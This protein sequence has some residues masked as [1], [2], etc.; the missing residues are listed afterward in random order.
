MVF[1][2]SAYA[3]ELVADVTQL[4]VVMGFTGISTDVEAWS[5]NNR[6]PKAHVGK[7]EPGRTRAMQEKKTGIAL[8]DAMRVRAK[9]LTDGTQVFLNCFLES[10][11]RSA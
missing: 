4:L 10:A 6:N 5:C 2:L 1:D 7:T 11:C 9:V 8:G 3:A